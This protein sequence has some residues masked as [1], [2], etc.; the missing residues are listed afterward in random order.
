MTASNAVVV[1]DKTTGIPIM[2]VVPDSDSQLKDP[3]FNPQN[4]T[5]IL[6]PME[7]YQISSHDQL[8]AIIDTAVIS[9]GIH[10]VQADSAPIGNV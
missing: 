6:V 5:Q 4:S 7:T 10:P 3:S 8:K 9:L 2:V 1:I